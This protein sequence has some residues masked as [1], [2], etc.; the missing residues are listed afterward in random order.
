[1]NMQIFATFC[2]LFLAQAFIIHAKPEPA[3]AEIQDATDIAEK[4]FVKLMAHIQEAIDE[5]SGTLKAAVQAVNETA[6]KLEDKAHDA[7]DLAMKPLN[8]KLKGLLEEAEKLGLNTTDCEHYIDDLTNL[9]NNLSDEMVDCMTDQIY[10][11][12]GYV[13]D[14]LNHLQEI[15]D[16]MANYTNKIHD[17]KGKI[18]MEV[19]CLAHLSAEMAKDTVDIP[20]KIAADVGKTVL[21]IKTLIPKVG[22]CYTKSLAQLP[23]QGLEIVHKFAECVGVPQN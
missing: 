19:T 16:T 23:I 1:M 21:A 10:K 6:T 2:I 14:I 3:A 11:A 12:T 5:A 7:F 22:L 18:W 20:L 17:C 15:E 4:L 9:P 8:A 13:D